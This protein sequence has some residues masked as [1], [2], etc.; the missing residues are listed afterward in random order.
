[1]RLTVSANALDMGTRQFGH[2]DVAML[3]ASKKAFF[4]DV[5]SHGLMVLKLKFLFKVK[6][7]EDL[8]LI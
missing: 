4:Y 5:R 7:G 6:F 1:M 2:V 3:L 8:G